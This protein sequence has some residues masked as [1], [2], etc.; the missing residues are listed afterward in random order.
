VRFILLLTSSLAAASAKALGELNEKTTKD[1]FRPGAHWNSWVRRLT[2]IMQK[3]RLPKTVPKDS[4]KRTRAVPFVALVRELQMCVPRQFR[5]HTHS[6]GALAQAIYR[7]R[8]VRR[9][10]PAARGRRGTR[11]AQSRSE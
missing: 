9:H 11:N 3:H 6:D 2:E 4:D 1:Y 10:H 5:R 8:S 7:A